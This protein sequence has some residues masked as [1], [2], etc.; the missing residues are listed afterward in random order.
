MFSL[1]ACG[2]SEAD[3]AAEI[4]GVISSYETNLENAN[5]SKFTLTSEYSNVC[6]YNHDLIDD[7]DKYRKFTISYD[8]SGYLYYKNQE[9]ETAFKE[10]W[11][12]IDGTNLIL[13]TYSHTS[14]KDTKRYD[15]L[16]FNS[17]EGAQ[18]RFLE[19]APK[20]IDK[21]EDWYYYLYNEI[22]EIPEKYCTDYYLTASNL[23]ERVINELDP[24]ITVITN[25]GTILDI[26]FSDDQ[27]YVFENG[28]LKSYN[29]YMGYAR[30]DRKAKA[31]DPI[32]AKLVA[33]M[34]TAAGADRVLTMDLHANQI[35]GFFDIPVDN[36]LGNPIFV[37]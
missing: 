3:V 13:A 2:E 35:Q 34:I 1:T 10:T 23:C 6:E 14:A 20:Y 32:S 16:E 12:Y 24:Y 30:Q 28:I 29:A 21:F 18:A 37:D 19:E 27:N 17:Y 4:K 26:K 11:L 25:D 7:I 8:D 22:Y 36:L 31:R 9:E 5:F 33:N 15:M